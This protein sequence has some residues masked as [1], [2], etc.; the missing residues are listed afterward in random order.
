MAVNLATTVPSR[1]PPIRPEYLGTMQVLET[2]SSESIIADRLEKLKEVWTSYDP[3][4]GAEFDVETTEFDPLVIQAE[5]SAYFELLL[6]DRVNQAT[7]AV[8]LA[9]AVGTDL[10]ALASLYPYG[11]PRKDNDGDGVADESDE[12]YRERLWLSPSIY[13]LMGP[14]QGTY[15][16]YV[17]WALSAPMPT[18]ELPIKNASALS[19]RGKG[20]VTIPIMSTSALNETWAVSN[21]RTIWTL[22]TGTNPVPTDLQISAVYEYITAP[23]VARQG[24][25]DYIYVVRP[26]VTNT[27][28]NVDIWLFPGVDKETLM[29]E[30]ATALVELIKGIQWLGADL[31]QLSLRGALA[32][33]GVYNCTIKSPTTDLVVGPTGCINVT[34]IT[35]TYKG[36]GE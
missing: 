5:L 36:V 7:R 4:A 3:P 16:S 30:I 10:D 19:R 6:R 22:T 31:T 23:S 35:L 32:Q 27:T 8:T 26:K 34:A 2:I 29:D 25:T 9:Y 11:V 15:E 17:F 13:S 21:D 24:L 12:S 1:F 28:I 18:G 20:E 14:G 33:S